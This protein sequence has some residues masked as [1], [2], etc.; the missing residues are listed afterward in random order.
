M[1]GTRPGRGRRGNGPRTLGSETGVVPCC[2]TEAAAASAAADATDRS[3]SGFRGLD[4]EGELGDLPAALGGV[5][6]N[7]RQ[8]VPERVDEAL[9]RARRFRLILGGHETAPCSA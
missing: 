3:P 1:S 9:S 2:F 7:Q 4:G 5:R 8:M 6:L